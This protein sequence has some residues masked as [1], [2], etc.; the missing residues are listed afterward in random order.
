MVLFLYV[1]S[2]LLLLP[3]SVFYYMQTLNAVTITAFA[4]WLILST[5]WMLLFSYLDIFIL[6]RWGKGWREIK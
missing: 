2:S 3:L 1:F 6:I 5:F 4:I